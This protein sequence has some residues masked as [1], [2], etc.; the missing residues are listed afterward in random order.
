MNSLLASDGLATPSTK[1]SAEGRKVVEDI[2]NVIISARN[3]VLVKNEGNMLQEFIWEAEH[4]QRPDV[5]PP[6]GP[7]DKGTAKQEGQQTAEGLKTLGTLIVTNGQFRKL[8]E[9]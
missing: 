2:R 3:L 6:G 7:V 5:Q 9:C 4:F 1:L 8:C